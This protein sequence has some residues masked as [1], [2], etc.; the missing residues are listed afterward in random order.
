MS[1]EENKRAIRRIPEEVVNTRNLALLDELVM[2][3]YIEHA[4]VP[5]GFPSGLAGLKQY[6]SMLLGAF[7][8]F[9]YTV[10][11]IVAEGE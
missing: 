2:S 3:D 5:P 10:E 9:H 1:I 11:D 6:Y 8:D 4:N 7:P